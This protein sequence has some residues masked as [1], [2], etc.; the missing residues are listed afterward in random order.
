MVRGDSNS[1]INLGVNENLTKEVIEGGK[2]VNFH[3][4]LSPLTEQDRESLVIKYRFKARKLSR[5]ILRRWHSRLDVEDVDSIVDLSLCEAVR[6]YDPSKG[7][8]FMTFLYFHL[9]GNLIRAVSD[10]VTGNGVVADDD[11]DS[12]RAQAAALGHSAPRGSARVA[13]ASE[14]TE[15]MYNVEPECPEDQMMKKELAEISNK[16]CEVLDPLEREVINRI[17]MKEEQLLAIA[18]SLGYSRCHI[19]RVKKRALEVLYIELIERI[20]DELG[21]TKPEDFNTNI[22]KTVRRRRSKN[23]DNEDSLEDQPVV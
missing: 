10:A 15:V 21:I 8:S 13:Y 19:S 2:Y 22:K 11:E 16:A 7:A 14:V 4:G 9:R 18:E 12:A 23:D 1:A 3:E 17:Y 20:G 5:S 6:R